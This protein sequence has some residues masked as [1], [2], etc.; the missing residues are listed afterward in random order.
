[1]PSPIRRISV[2]TI[3]HRS[4]RY[5]TIG[6]Y[7]LDGETLYVDVSELGDWRMSLLCAVHEIIEAALCH[8]DGV[9]FEDIN[10]FDIEFEAQRR[11]GAHSVFAEPGEDPHAPYRIQHAFADGVERLFA[12]QLG[13][14]WDEYTDRVIALDFRENNGERQKERLVDSKS[15]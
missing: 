7:Y 8:Q 10:A 13:V 2:E 4:Q 11:R 5:D 15:R 9:P 12:Q 14:V 3:S 6:D 1:M